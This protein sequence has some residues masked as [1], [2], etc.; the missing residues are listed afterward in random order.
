MPAYGFFI[1]NVDDVE[2]DNVRFTTIEKDARPAFILDE[3]H[4]A[5]VRDIETEIVVSENCTGIDLGDR[6]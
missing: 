6:Q 1:R 4:G 3:V 2:I 5:V